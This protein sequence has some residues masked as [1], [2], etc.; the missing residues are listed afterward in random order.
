LREGIPNGAAARKAWSGKYREEREKTVVKIL[1]VDDDRAEPIAVE[2][3]A[4]KGP[5]A[6][7]QADS[8]AKAS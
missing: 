4:G 7:E 5:H 6:T 3:C 1:I 2:P 8:A